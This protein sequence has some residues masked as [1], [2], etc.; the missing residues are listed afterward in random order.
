MLKGVHFAAWARLN[1]ARL[2]RHP[3]QE[4]EALVQRKPPT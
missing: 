1:T 3:Q 2:F 4:H